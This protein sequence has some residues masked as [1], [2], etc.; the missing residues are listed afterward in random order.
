MTTTATERDTHE[1]LNQA[2]PLAPYDVF[3]A[4]LALCEALE[5]EGGAWGVERMRELGRLAG[6]PEAADHANRAERN[7]PILRTHDRYGNRIDQVELDPS[8]H[9][10]LRQAIERE[11]HGLPWR[12]PQPGAHVVR[13]GLFFVWSQVSSGVMCPVS[14]TYSA[15]PA[16]REAPELAAEWEP[17]LTKPSYEDGA[18]AGMA[19]SSRGT[20]GSAPIP[21]ATSS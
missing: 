18:L 9:W 4:D 2:P 6:S 1:V 20:S 8:W 5:R 7:L 17:R 10:L 19:M 11:I 14:M 15:I 21:P 12:D 16:L 13:A 3:E